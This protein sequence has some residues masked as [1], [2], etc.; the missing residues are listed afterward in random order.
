MTNMNFKPQPA[1][2]LLALLPFWDPQIPPLGIACLKGFARRRGFPVKTVDANIEAD[3]RGIDHHYFELLEQ[4]IPPERRRHLY[5]IGHDVFRNHAMAHL[6]HQEARDYYDLVKVLV[7]RTFFTEIRRAQA[8]ALNRL[9]D[10]FYHRFRQYFLDL[11]ATQRPSLLGLSV[12]SGTLPAS[13]FAF[14]LAREN[15]PRI[16]TVMGGGIFSGELNMENEN[17]NRFLEK[18]PYIDRIIVGEGETL[19]LKLLKGE[20]PAEQRIFSLKDI[21][22]RTEPIAGLPS[23]DFSDFDL[24]YFPQM[25]SY[26]SRSCPFQCTFCVETIYWGKYRKKEAS[27]IVE[28][29]TTL[30]E[31]HGRQLFL[32][33]D[34]LLN[35]V[36]EP[37]ASEFVNTELCLY[38]GG[39]LRVEE[40]VCRP[41]YTLKWR[42]GGFYRARLGLESGSQRVLDLMDKRITVEQIR[43]AVNSLAQAG[44]KTTTYWVIGYPGE[45]A[46]DFQRTLDLIEEMK[47]D[48]YEADCNPFWYFG[49]GQVSSGEWSRSRRSLPLY[50]PEAQEVLLL[51]SWVIDGP[52]HRRE[53][54]RRVNRFIEH[55]EELGIPNPYSFTEICRADQR[56]QRLHRNA[57]PPL[58]AFQDSH[59]CVDECR[60]VKAVSPARNTQVYDENWS[61]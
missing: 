4:F 53:T 8:E 56:W 39:Y 17:F 30:Y 14:R 52:P 36:I 41:E 18:T 44:I 34:S 12:Y 47:D 46:E 31:K 1:N 40:R 54:Y 60:R 26:T 51:Q 33:C 11:L 28:E 59:G 23:P 37:L 57:V 24:H 61:F 45:T 48:I 10:D 5:N 29:L 25:A 13:L 19:F 35:P 21:D 55:I 49:G 9:L 27:G 16:E 2:I 20:L 38:W 6:N 32:M 43:A 3:F 58:M 7:E 50:P 42:R 22:Y 15:Y